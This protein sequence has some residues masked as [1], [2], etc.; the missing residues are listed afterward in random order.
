MLSLMVN[1]VVGLIADRSANWMVLMFNL[2]G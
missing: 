1:L 2:N